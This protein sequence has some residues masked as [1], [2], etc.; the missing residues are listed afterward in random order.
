MLVCAFGLHTSGGMWKPSRT[1]NSLTAKAGGDSA[2]SVKRWQGN[3]RGWE[4]PAQGLL[5]HGHYGLLAQA[6]APAVCNLT[7]KARHPKG[8]NV[9]IMACGRSAA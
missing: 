2:D 5:S 6:P 8:H 3:A 9:I 1:L 7:R 4:A